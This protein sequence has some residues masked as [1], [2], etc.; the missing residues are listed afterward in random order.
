MKSHE[1]NKF[2]EGSAQ[3]WS[4]PPFI[5][6]RFHLKK[7]NSLLGVDLLGILTE[8]ISLNLFQILLILVNG[9]KV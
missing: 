4:F 2:C 7:K 1:S 5:Q 6:N 9:N 3:F 8:K